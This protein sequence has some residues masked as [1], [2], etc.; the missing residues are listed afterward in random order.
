MEYVKAEC[1]SCEA[2]GL[3]CGFV[4]SEGTAV[5]CLSCDGSGCKTISYRP[6]IKRKGRLGI[7]TVSLSRGSFILSCGSVGD[8]ITYKEFTK[9]AMPIKESK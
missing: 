2:S 7:K 4:E 8:S 5:V 9:G 6:F 3:Y 1:G